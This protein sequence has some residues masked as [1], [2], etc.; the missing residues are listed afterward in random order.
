[1]YVS[2]IIPQEIDAT[3]QKMAAWRLGHTWLLG[4]VDAVRLHRIY[5]QPWFAAVILFASVS[6]GF[7]S[8]DQL[9]AA[10]KRL[11]VIG[12]GSGE[13]I[14]ESVPEHQLSAIARA[15]RYRRLQ[16]FSA[17]HLKFVRNPW[18]YFGV[19]MLHAG[20]T[21]AVVVSLYV[22]LTGRQG[23][24]ILV[25]GVPHG[26]AEP[27][28]G[29][30]H[31]MLS[32]PLKLPGTI[33]LDKVRVS[34]DR[35]N[36]PTDVTSDI[37]VTGQTGVDESFT[38]SINR[39]NRYQGMRFYHAAEYGDAFTVTFTDS[40][41][42]AFTEKIL[43]Q[44]PVNL[45]KAGYS[46]DFN[47]SWS[48]NRFGVKYFADAEN[49][50]MNSRNPRLVVRALAGD[51]EIARTELTT[52]NS[53]MLGEYRVRL[54]SVTHWAKIIIVDISGMSVIFAGFAIIMLGSIIHYMT[55]PR[56]LIGVKNQDGSYQVYWKAVAFKDFYS[57]ER[58]E[59]VREL[60]RESCR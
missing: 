1:M 13:E 21:L 30:E 9:G 26:S 6:L 37:S 29:S 55:P 35:N 39:I 24:L 49:K 52:G 5:A 7:S 44:Q 12:T 46:S 32:S 48:A 19:V 16:P 59:I 34:F 27:W 40:N 42:T 36:R 50:S 53:A 51:K 60:K 58:D 54:D 8:F 22:S 4:L 25:E 10:K 23:A 11:A 31:G 18:G 15:Y 43:A 41:G 28:D 2:T 38:A 45:E 57:D 33:R 3:P 20:L 14:A 47:V 56:E 17:D